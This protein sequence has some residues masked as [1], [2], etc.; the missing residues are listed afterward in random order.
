MQST[1]AEF[2]GIARP[3]LNSNLEL[4]HLDAS[5]STTST[6]EEVRDQ[7]LTD[8]ARRMTAKS[9]DE[10]QHTLLPE[11]STSRLDP[12][13]PDF[14]PKRWVRAFYHTRARALD[15]TLPN[16]AGLAFQRLNVFGQSEMANYQKTV[17]GLFHSS[18]DYLARILGSKKPPRVDILRDIEGVVESGEMV[19]VLGPPGSGCSTLLKTIAGETYGFSVDR[20]SVLNYQG[21]APEQISKAYK[22]EAI[23]AAEVDQHF[24]RLTVGETL[25]FAARARCPRNLEGYAHE[26]AEHIRDVTMALLGISHT[27]NTIVGNDFIRG[28]SGGERKRVTIAEAILNYSPWQCWDN[29]TRGLDSA[30]AVEFCRT[31]RLQSQVFGSSVCVAIYQAPREAYDL[32]DKVIVL[33]QGRQIFFGRTTEAKAYF[34]SL[35][36]YC[37]DQ[38]TTPDFLTS[39]TSASERRVRP[40]W[41]G[42]PPPQSPDE[43]AQAWKDSRARER[44]MVDIESFQ[45]RFPIGGSQAQSFRAAQAVSRPSSPYTLSLGGQLSLNLWRSYKLLISDPWMTITMLLTNFFEAIIVSSIFYN[46]PAESSSIDKR[47]LLIFFAVVMN[48]LGS[49]LEVLTLYDKRKIIEKHRRY[50]LYHP[51]TEAMA[52]IIMSLP[53][54]VVNSCLVNITLYFMCNLRREPGPFFFFFLVTTTIIIT[55]SMAFRF[56]ASVTTTLSQALAPAAIVLLAVVTFSGFAIPQAY[57][58][59]WIGWLRWINPVFYAQESISLS[60]FVG[61]QFP[62]TSFVPSGPG[63]ASSLPDASRVCSIEG[64][65]AGQPFVDGAAHIRVTYGFVN[66]HRWR[67][68]GIIVTLTIFFMILHLAATELVT[69]ERSKGEV[70]IY[71]RKFLKKKSIPDEEAAGSRSSISGTRRNGQGV[72]KQTSVFHWQDICYTIKIKGEPR[73]ILDHV[74]GWVK[75]GTLTALMGVS[76]AGKT[77]LLDALACR[78]TMGV[79]TGHALVNGCPLDLTFQRKTGYATQQDLHLHTATV[80]E[81]LRFSAILRQPDSYTRQEKLEYVEEVIRLVDLDD[82]ADAVIGSPGQGLNVEQRKRLTIG[83]ELAARPELL[84]FLDEPTS[85]LD[86]QTSWAICDLMEKLTKNG[87]AIL[88]TIHQPSAA[89]FQRFDRLLL[90]AKGGKT[91]YFGEV[92]EGSSVLIDYFQRNG[93]PSFQKGMNPAEYMLDVI[94]ATPG[95]KRIDNDWPAIWRASPEYQ[96]VHEELKRLCAH[97]VSTTP[98]AHSEFAAGIVT[99]MVQ[100]TK[101]VFQQYWRT[102]SYIFSKIVLTAGSALFIGLCQINPENTQRGLFNQLISVFIFLFIFSQ[103]I[104]QAMP[105]FVFQRTLYEARE[106]PA[107]AY[108]WVAFLFAT[109][110]V[111]LVWNSIMSVFSFLFWYFPMGMYRN[112]EFTD[113]VHSRGITVFLQIWAFFV[114]SSTFGHMII[115]GIDTAEVAGGIV[116]LFFIMMVAFSGVLAT[117]QELPGFWIFMYRVNPFTYMIEGFVAT[118]LANAPM[119]CLNRELVR[120]EAPDGM[121][122]GEYMAPYIDRNGGFLID[123]NTSSCDFCTVSDSNVFLARTNLSFDNRWRDFGFIWAYSIFNII[124]AVFMYWLI[125]VSKRKAR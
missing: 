4:D 112:A 24:P 97:A 6:P 10:S 56:L 18:L 95:S 84:L 124:V 93:A 35:G 100:V 44:L 20:N 99:Q 90:L 94:G 34:E 92:G 78:I 39:M 121:T 40:G 76:G 74:D 46:L 110:T 122:C 123:S 53:Y 66:E 3:E 116:N 71:P 61:R 113:S 109:I 87:Q 57:I 7:Q 30:N 41:Q 117:P 62:C 8:L 86:S 29:S 77:T 83:I 17:G 72:V 75:P 67:N 23:Y 37:P 36:F 45:Q 115:A 104:E 42:K 27:K 105:M 47:N 50:A 101:R 68:Y 98:T 85:G 70:L 22:G 15:G 63:Y 60:E 51:S 19:C 120:F 55:M 65:V 80:R 81:A 89:L 5:S 114:F 59:N 69:S 91:V 82:C 31:L 119:H 33:Y 118:S 49:L 73:T 28:V 102:P 52:S 103:L 96:G 106:R 1:P 25:Y 2:P 13:S 79:V 11:P 38:Q 107:K 43:F 14:D 111:E 108:S 64:S 9:W 88:C 48:A 21:L 54:K 32:F 58:D 125:R 16:T 26:Y 12:H